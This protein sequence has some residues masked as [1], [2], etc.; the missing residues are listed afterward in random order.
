M[1]QSLQ[2][3]IGGRLVDGTSGR[4]GN[5]YNPAT[6]AVSAR[7]PLASTD[8][9]AAVVRAC[10]AAGASIV[11]Q[12]GNT[13][14]AVASVPDDSGTQVVLSLR[15]MDAVRAI[16]AANLTITVE[17]GGILQNLQQAAE[18]AG[19]ELMP[20]TPQATPARARYSMNS[21]SPPDAPPRPPGFWR[22]WVT[23]YTTGQP[24]RRMIGNPRM[25][26]TRAL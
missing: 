9:V 11:P 21:E 23:S 6:G 16:D 20:S 4:F 14:L 1:T 18:Q 24:R 10:A 3:F 17:A 5:V 12:G 26:T 19:F 8:E 22:L 25:S 13:G 7:V 15:R 2:H